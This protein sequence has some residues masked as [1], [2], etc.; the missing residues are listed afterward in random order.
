MK[1]KLQHL[2]DALQLRPGQFARMLEINPAIISHILAERNKPGVDLLQKILS[3][4]P[5]VSP[6]W[7]LLDAGPMF[8][9][10]ATTAPEAAAQPANR[11]EQNLFAPEPAATG[12]PQ[13]TAPRSA[14]PA[15][16][17]SA[18]STAPTPSAQ[19]VAQAAHT[20][21]CATGKKPVARIVLLY[22]DGTFDSF[23]PGSPAPSGREGAV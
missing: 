7:L 20:T 6:D 3:R 5:Q 12:E 8:R 1:E 23:T 16:A 14:A 9:D 11:A 18:A 4:F 17:T 21:A 22:A 2:M 19:S 10:D 13:A 15:L